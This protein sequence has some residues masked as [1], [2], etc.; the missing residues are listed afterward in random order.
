[1]NVGVG[2]FVDAA[3]VDGGMV[4][5]DGKPSGYKQE[6]ARWGADN[7]VA[8]HEEEVGEKVAIVGPI[9]YGAVDA[10]GAAMGDGIASGFVGLGVEA[11]GLKVDGAVNAASAVVAVETSLG[12]G[13]VFGGVE[14]SGAKDE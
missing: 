5:V 14:V 4:F 12:V 6:K 9:L 10:A 8:V 11:F 1:M 7:V 3:L 2:H 13:E